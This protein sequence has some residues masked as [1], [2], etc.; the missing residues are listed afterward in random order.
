MGAVACMHFGRAATSGNHLL[1]VQ[2]VRSRGI[3]G[4][5]LP[6]F[7]ALTVTV[8][9]A[10]ALWEDVIRS[11]GKLSLKQVR[12]YRSHCSP[13]QLPLTGPP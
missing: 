1:W 7:S 11:F 12:L 6:S 5:D 13:T 9:G 8:P 10:P 3:T 4:L 2:E